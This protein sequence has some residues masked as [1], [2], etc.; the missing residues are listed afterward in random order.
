MAGFLTFGDGLLFE[1]IYIALLVFMAVIFIRDINIVSI[2]VISAIANLSSELLYFIV[3]DSE[4]QI[5][6]KLMVYVAICITLFKLKTEEFR[7]I[8]SVVIGLCI[9]AEMYWIYTGYDA[10]S[11]YWY[12]L[13]ININL[14]VR[15]FLFSRV[16]ITSKYFPKRYRSLDLDISLHSL[17]WYY[18][19]VHMAVL[20]EYL[21]RRIFDVSFAEIYYAAP[22][23]FHGLTTYSALLIMFQGYKII[24]YEWFKA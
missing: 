1:K 7:I 2:I 14:A 17:V 20:I 18:I 3:F 6:T 13:L 23:V 24:R 5:A 10:P 16:F 15:F 8:I 22:Y 21:V 11:I 4:Y 12:V 9:A 19:L